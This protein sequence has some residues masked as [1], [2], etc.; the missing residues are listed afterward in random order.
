MSRLVFTHEGRAW[1]VTLDGDEVT[2]KHGNDVITF[3]NVGDLK[4]EIKEVVLRYEC[5]KKRSMLKQ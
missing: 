1:R 4:E 5:N 3:T 2:L